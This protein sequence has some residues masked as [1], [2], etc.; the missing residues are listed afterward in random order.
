MEEDKYSVVRLY[1][2]L[3][4]GSFVPKNQPLNKETCAQN[5][6]DAIVDAFQLQEPNK[7]TTIHEADREGVFD[8][9]CD[10]L[11]IRALDL[12]NGWLDVANWKIEKYF[13]ALYFFDDPGWRFYLPAYLV[14][15]L[16]CGEKSTSPTLEYLVG[17][18]TR[19]QFDDY[20]DSLNTHQSFL[21]F[22]FLEH[23]AYFD[24]GGL[25]DEALEA[26]RSYWQAFM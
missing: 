24:I 15:A 22:K 20:F 8:S 6:I 17:R 23:V 16:R 7:G 18:L 4:D 12:E 21:V 13:S 2:V 3:D 25:R 19:R 14:W 26:I 11:Q 1:N 9:D 5:L 10:R